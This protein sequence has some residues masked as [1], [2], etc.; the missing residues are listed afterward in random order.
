[1]KKVYQK[2]ID[3]NTGDCMQAVIAS[4]FEVELNDVPEFIK[5]GEH[6][7][8]MMRKFF[9]DHGYPHLGYINRGMGIGTKLLKR[10]AKFDRGIN[11]YLYASVLSQNFADGC[12][13]AVVVDTDLNI[14]HDPSPNQSSMCLTP[15]DILDI[16]VTKPII[17]GRT[18]KVFTYEE[19]DQLNEKERA[20]NIWNK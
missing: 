3:K 20:C 11:G 17:I 12:G 6:W 14:V 15:D 8:W 18:G 4:L 13:H 5:L 1:M 2:V 16:M 9:S 10:V 19:Y 7:F